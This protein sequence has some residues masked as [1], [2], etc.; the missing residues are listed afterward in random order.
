[1]NSSN[2]PEKRIQSHTP[3]VPTSSSNNC[4]HFPPD[5]SSGFWPFAH[6]LMPPFY[7]AGIP[8]MF[9]PPSPIPVAMPFYYPGALPQFD[10]NMRV[11]QHS[12]NNNNTTDGCVR[13][14]GASNNNNNTGNN[15]MIQFSHQTVNQSVGLPIG[16]STTESI[17]LKG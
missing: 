4:Q 15:L 8:T 9:P 1:M 16:D 13:G 14:G 3:S 10:G 5:C 7:T 17:V 2:S 12:A 6:Q 11:L